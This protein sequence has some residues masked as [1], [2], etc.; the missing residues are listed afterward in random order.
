MN[1]KVDRWLLPDGIEEV[2]PEQALYLESLRRRFVDL[3][4]RWGYDY[5]IPPMIEF[6]DSLLTGSGQDIELLTFKLTDQLSGRTLGLRADITPQ[7]ARM[8]AHSLK[9]SGVNRLCYAG[10]VLQ[11]K[12]K[13]PLGSRSPIKVGVEMFGVS[14]LE[15]E[16]EVVSLLLE[17]LTVANLDCQYIDL[18]HVGIF[19]CL[20]RAAELNTEQESALFSLLQSKAFS[21]IDRWLNENVKDEQA[22]QW[23]SALSKLSGSDKIIELAREAFADA[24]SEIHAALDDLATLADTVLARYPNVQL[25]FDL[26]ELRGYHYHTGIV[27]GAFAPGVG[28]AIARGGRYDSVGEA[29]GRARSATGFD[30]N[31]SAICRLQRHECSPP[32]KGIFACHE[33]GEAL[34]QKVQEL[35]AQGERVVMGVPGQAMPEDY[36]HCDRILCVENDQVLLKNM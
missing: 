29:F 8:D 27:F 13:S 18:G 7:A 4:I 26:S 25:Y 35:R 31:L 10:H 23:L 34:W 32:D 17:A 22:R 24:P 1:N 36:Q 14:A 19:R 20:A 15:A 21:D 3:F 16:V 6:T 9:R 30:I 11:T 33:A 28:N 5:V 12:A 2:L